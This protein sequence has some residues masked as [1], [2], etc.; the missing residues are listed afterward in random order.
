VI[1]ATGALE[2][3]ADEVD[4]P[5]LGVTLAVL[6]LVTVEVVVCVSVAVLVFVRVEVAALGVSAS[7]GAAT[8]D[9]DRV[10][11][12]A[13]DAVGKAMEG[14]DR[15]GRGGAADTA[16][17]MAELRLPDPQAP[18]TAIWPRTRTTTGHADLRRRIAPPSAPPEHMRRTTGP[19]EGWLDG[20]LAVPS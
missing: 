15:L 2:P 8:D 9:S 16:E 11:G 12:G 13:T 10:G 7:V 3:V 6:V 14:V 19:L 1:V 20:R 5:S 17:E 4:P 18:S